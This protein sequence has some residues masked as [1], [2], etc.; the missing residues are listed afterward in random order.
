M[1]SEFD[2]SH[3]GKKPPPGPQELE[4]LRG[5]L[6]YQKRKRWE[7]KEALEQERAPKLGGRLQAL[8]LVR[9]EGGGFFA[10]HDD[11]L[12]STDSS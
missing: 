7:A 6:K 3:L 11:D 1:Y 12:K 5:R 2:V 9:A 8:W 4:R 10:L